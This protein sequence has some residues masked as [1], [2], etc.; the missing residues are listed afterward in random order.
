MGAA[1]ADDVGSGELTALL[2]PAHATARA[3][4]VCRTDAVLCGQAWFGACFRR[5][6]PAVKITAEHALYG[7]SY[8]ISTPGLEAGS[9]KH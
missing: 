7:L 9:G 4:I 8:M 1:L 5:L 6:G 3:T 2:T